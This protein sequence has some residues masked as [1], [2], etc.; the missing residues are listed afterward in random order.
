MTKEKNSFIL[1]YSCE[2]QLQDLTDEQL[3]K[4]LRLIFRYEIDGEL[5]EI[6]DS[7]IKMAFAF[8]KTNLDINKSKY[9]EKCQKNTDN[10]N[11]RWGNASGTDADKPS[12]EADIGTD[13]KPFGEQGNIP[14]AV[15]IDII[16][17][18]YPNK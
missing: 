13:D 7:A 1:Y 6:K 11:K 4:L 5:P 14:L 10:I 9:E 18:K 12:G 8:I 2:E 17:A 16:K 15:Q 3:G